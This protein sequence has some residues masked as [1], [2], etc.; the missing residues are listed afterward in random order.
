MRSMRNRLTALEGTSIGQD[1]AGMEKREL[2]RQIERAERASTC[3]VA[4]ALV[5]REGMS[6]DEAIRPMLAYYP[7]HEARRLL[8]L[9]YDEIYRAVD[10]PMAHTKSVNKPLEV[11][12]AERR[13]CGVRI[14]GR[15]HAGN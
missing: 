1:Q 10:G 7:E 4:W 6:V 11:P 9:G 5:R 2:D 12:D 15:W 13:Q 3:L 14:P 8:D